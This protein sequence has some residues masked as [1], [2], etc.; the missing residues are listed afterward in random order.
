MVH[1]NADKYKT[2]DEAA[3]QPDGL[4]VLGIFLEVYR[5]IQM[6]ILA[7]LILTNLLNIYNYLI[8]KMKNKCLL[9]NKKKYYKIFIEIMKRCALFK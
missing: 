6:F 5:S 2:F 4:S 3:S 9:Y 1:W 8:N 7:Y